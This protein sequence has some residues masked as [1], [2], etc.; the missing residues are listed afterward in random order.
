M[1]Y[2][3]QDSVQGWFQGLRGD[4]DDLDP[5]LESL[6]VEYVLG[7]LRERYDVSGWTDDLDTPTLVLSAMALFYAGTW[8]NAHYHE[9]S[10]DLSGYGAWLL[11]MADKILMGLNAGDLDLD[12]DVDPVISTGQPTYWPTDAATTIADEEGMWADGAA[13]RHFATGMYF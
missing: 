10:D 5:A 6:A 13:V 8:Y 11:G 7:A 1:A 2:L 12:S 3:T 9:Q 4:V